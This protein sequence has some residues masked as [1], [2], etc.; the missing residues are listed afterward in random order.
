MNIYCG[1]DMVEIK[2]I[3][4]SVDRFE[5]SFVEKIFTIEEINYCEDKKKNKYQS[6]AARFAVKEAVSKALGT[7][8]AKGVT[9]KDI[10]VTVSD[11]GKP[12]V[13]LHGIARELFI[14]MSGISIDISLTHT[15]EYATAF[16]VILCAK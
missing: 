4:E 7:G 10:E 13:I 14:N 1:V 11:V 16:A 8:F 15:A 3:K 12:Y 9:L 5:N 2:R 6:Y